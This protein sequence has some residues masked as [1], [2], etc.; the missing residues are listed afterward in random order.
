MSLAK[1]PEKKAVVDS[2]NESVQPRANAALKNFRALAGIEERV[3]MPRDPG[4]S[5]T[6][7]F[8]SGY[9]EMAKP[10]AEAKENSAHYK[11]MRDDAKKIK[12]AAND[13]EKAHEE[14]VEVAEARTKEQQLAGLKK[15]YMQRRKQGDSYF[16][17]LK[18]SGDARQDIADTM[19]HNREPTAK[20]VNTHMAREY[21]K[22]VP[23]K[24]SIAAK[25][26]A[27]KA[28]KDAGDEDSMAAT[29]PNTP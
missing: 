15:S 7:R 17:P 13:V 19:S 14:D 10:F 9:E 27:A 21:V 8:N 25:R 23:L 18:D 2:V 4:V 3:M 12:A 1:P 16:T 29:M 22:K 11:R 6:T 26:Q 20:D 5:G 28:A 24:G